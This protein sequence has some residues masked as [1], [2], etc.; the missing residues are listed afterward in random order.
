MHLNWEYF[1]LITFFAGYLHTFTEQLLIN[2]DQIPG[3]QQLMAFIGVDQGVHFFQ[4][5]LDGT[6][7][8]QYIVNDVDGN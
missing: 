5:F 3:D 2:L 4:F 6:P 1:D 8:K 7:P